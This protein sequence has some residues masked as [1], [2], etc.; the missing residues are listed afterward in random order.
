MTR[1]KK[2]PEWITPDDVIVLEKEKRDKA[3]EYRKKLQRGKREAAGSKK[4]VGPGSSPKNPMKM[5]SSD[6]MPDC[7]NIVSDAMASLKWL[8]QPP[9]TVEELAERFN[10]YFMKCAELSRV[11]TITGLAVAAGV[12]PKELN[13]WENETRRPGSGFSDVVK[14]AKTTVRYILESVAVAGKMPPVVYIFMGKNYFG[15]SDKV[16]Q[17][18]SVKNPLTEIETGEELQKRIAESIPADFEEEE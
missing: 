8:N 9:D 18:I 5:M 7:G 16:E 1:K 11:P 4:V 3:N 14:H 12:E 10:A 15:M 17:E 2:E 13:A 6:N